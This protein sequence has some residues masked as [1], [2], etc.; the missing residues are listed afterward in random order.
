MQTMIELLSS[1]REPYP[2]WLSAGPREFDGSGFFASRTLYYPG[3][4]DDGQPVRLCAQAHAAH[5]FVYVDYG[6]SQ[7]T[8]SDRV[9][10]PERGF[11]GYALEHAESVSEADL[12]PGGWQAHVDSSKRPESRHTFATAE[13]FAWFTVLRRK[14]GEGYGDAHGP[15][16][17]AGLFVGGDGFATYDAL[18]CQGDGTPAP[19]LVVIQDHGFGGNWSRFGRGGM[20]ER[21][22][23]TCSALPEHLLVAENSRPWRGYRAADAGSE[24]GG[25]H[26]H[27]RRLFSRD[28]N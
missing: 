2:E 17:L 3:S 22:A 6:V 12:R 7:Q 21:T 28:T 18:Y 27:P 4:G 19:F 20:L 16:R 13:P 8:L 9:R 10:D 15:E 1:E 5:A 23:R 25:Q 26:G 14:D 11:R 24:S